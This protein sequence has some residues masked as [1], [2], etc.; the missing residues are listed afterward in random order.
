MKGCDRMDYY[1]YKIE[2]IVNHKKYIGLTNNIQRRRSRHFTDLKCNRHDNSFL[3]KEYNI[4]GLENFSFEVIYNGDCTYEEISDKEK[5]YIK[6]YD[7]YYN[8]YNQNE[9]GNFGPSNGGSHLTKSDIF[10]ICAALEF[11]SRPG[12][13][14]AKMFEITT[15]TVSRIKHKANHIE[16]IAEYEKMPLEERQKIY[17]IFLNSSNF[18]EDKVNATIIKNKRK[19]SQEQVYMIFANEEFKI[20]P[21]EYFCNMF[22]VASNTIYTILNRKSY[23]DYDFSYKQ[24]SLE[25]KN[26]I[27]SLLR[28]QQKQTRRIAGKSQV[29]NQQLSLTN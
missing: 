25:D 23:K 15:T 11:C 13:I 12:A 22:N 9:G 21:I 8:G 24:L 20:I 16:I 17:Q 3:Q 2:N 28:N 7:S 1:I 29:D 4:Y 5:Y 26:K 18:Y 6:E 19:L 14:L 10:N 27:V